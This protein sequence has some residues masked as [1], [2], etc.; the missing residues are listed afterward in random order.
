[1]QSDGTEVN[2]SFSRAAREM[3]QESRNEPKK[4]NDNVTFVGSFFDRVTSR[5]LEFKLNN[6]KLEFEG[7]L[8]RRNQCGKYFLYALIMRFSC[9]AQKSF[10][11]RESE[12]KPKHE[13]CRIDF[14]FIQPQLENDEQQNVEQFWR[15]TQNVLTWASRTF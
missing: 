10:N 4:L 15:S 1:M 8:T 12:E 3:Q 2:S 6:E 7:E 5:E 14:Y 11:R 9:Y 13:W